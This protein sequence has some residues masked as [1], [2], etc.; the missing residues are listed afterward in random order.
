M[1]GFEFVCD[2]LLCVL[3]FVFNFLFDGMLVEEV[4]VLFVWDN[5]VY[6]GVGFGYVVLMY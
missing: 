1:Y 4:G 6:D 3:W 2:L 5:V